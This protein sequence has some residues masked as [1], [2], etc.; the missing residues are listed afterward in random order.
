MSS[1]NCDL[2]V[3]DENTLENL[4]LLSTKWLSPLQLASLAW[5]NGLV[6]RKGRFSDSE[7]EQVKT[8]IESYQRVPFHVF[9][10]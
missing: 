6:Y 10:S 1:D 7:G 8:A 4:E 5:D 9:N 3:N 2:G